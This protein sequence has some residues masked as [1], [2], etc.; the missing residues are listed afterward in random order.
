MLARRT[1]RAL[2]AAGD[3]AGAVGVLCDLALEQDLPEAPLL[4]AA[5]ADPGLTP[6][7]V[8]QLRGA[9]GFTVRFRLRAMTSLGGA[10]AAEVA[11]VPPLAIQTDGERLLLARQ[12]MRLCRRV[13]GAA[14]PLP[15]AYR[16]AYAPAT[17]DQPRHLL[18]RR[19][20][21]GSYLDVDIGAERWLAL[22]LADG[23]HP[24]FGSGAP[25]ETGRPIALDAPLFVLGGAV[26][27]DPGARDVD[28]VDEI[29]A[30]SVL[31][32]GAACVNEWLT[33]RAA[34]R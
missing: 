30:P 25:P 18:A 22:E 6:V 19:L 33:S 13:V 21:Q 4:R 15:D 2:A 9:W 5:L 11:L 1:L 16:V 7:A 8:S 12:R 17:A 14:L 32:S 29:A 10:P 23:R 24:L 3:S 31:A 28:L 26:S 27:Y 34:H 20:T